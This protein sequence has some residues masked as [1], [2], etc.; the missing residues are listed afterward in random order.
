M[1]M[2][3]RGDGR[4]FA[5][6]LIMWSKIRLFLPRGSGDAPHA[7]LHAPRSQP[8]DPAHID[9]CRATIERSRQY[10]RV[11]MRDVALT[12]HAACYN[13]WIGHPSGGRD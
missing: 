12:F 5:A 9:R 11:T 3:V 2:R 8:G 4:R 6:C 10:V 7:P 1:R 13:A